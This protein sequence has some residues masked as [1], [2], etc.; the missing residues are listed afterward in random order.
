V[1]SAQRPGEDVPRQSPRLLPVGSTL[2]MSLFLL[3][4]GLVVLLATP[5]AVVIAWPF[6][7]LRAALRQPRPR[8]VVARRN[9]PP[10]A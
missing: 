3:F 10:H 2:A 4:S 1:P 5:P 8:T 9:G 6:L 7:L